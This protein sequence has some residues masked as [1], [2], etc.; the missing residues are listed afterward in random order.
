M[1]GSYDLP[2]CLRISVGLEDE[3]KALTDAL[4]EHLG[5]S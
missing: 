2:D 5:R 3:M 4:A 1:M